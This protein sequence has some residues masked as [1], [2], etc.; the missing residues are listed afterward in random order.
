MLNSNFK[1]KNF[2]LIVVTIIL[3]LFFFEIYF[4]LTEIILPSFVYDDPN[5]GRTHRPNSLV[6][7]VGAEGFY[8]G[9]INQ[10]GYPG[11][12]YPP[13][14]P[15]SVFRIALIGDSYV[16]GFQ[17]F[18]RHHFAR[19][20][21]NELNK[22]SSNKIEILNFGT[23]GA[24]FRGMYLR[25]TKIAQKFNPDL[26]LYFIKQEDLLKKDAVPMPEPILTQDSIV[27]KETVSD[28]FETELRNK[29]ALVR[30][31]STGN[32]LKEVFEVIFA[33]RFLNAVLDKFFIF[34]SP[35]NIKKNN[36]I[37][38]NDRFFEHNKRIIE[39]LTQQNET[40]GNTIIV[41]AEKLPLI[42][43]KL[44]KE[45]HIVA[46]PLYIELEKHPKEKLNYWKA[47]GKFGH[48]NQNAHKTVSDYLINKLKYLVKL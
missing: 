20:I 2:F 41:E 19:L 44:L 33:G 45:N 17:L 37:S 29:F 21:E 26:T 25:H 16:E 23:G 12:E 42:Y 35:E 38:E 7:L 31:F 39:L 43:Q 3:S 8:M 11:K 1:L 48:W 24:D 10:Y 32:L 27:F 4:R 47:S 18:E 36:N 34:I 9:K 40:H 13:E 28:N 30:I 22:N 46:I 5:L 14:K 15:D 6:N